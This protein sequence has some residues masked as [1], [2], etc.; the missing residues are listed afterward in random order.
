MWQQEIF[1]QSYDV[2]I[3]PLVIYGLRGGHIQAH[4]YKTQ[5]NIYLHENDFKKPGTRQPQASV[6]LI[7][8]N[9]ASTVK[10]LGD[11]FH[12]IHNV[13]FIGVRSKG[14]V[15]QDS[16]EVFRSLLANLQ[17]MKG[18]TSEEKGQLMQLYTSCICI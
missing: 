8:K 13:Y 9:L 12:C 15:V 5:T 14:V 18:L 16:I 10:P 17:D 4:T 6:H 7:L 3:T 1:N 11:S 2:Q